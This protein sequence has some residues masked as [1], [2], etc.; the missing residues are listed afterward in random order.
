MTIDMMEC[1]HTIMHL[2]FVNLGA[3]SQP[4]S[5]DTRRFETL[6]LQHTLV[7]VSLILQNPRISRLSTLPNNVLPM[8]L[9]SP[10]TLKSGSI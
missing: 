6:C 4:N 5:F 2:P 3:E 10:S 8:K 9:D 1:Q 7:R